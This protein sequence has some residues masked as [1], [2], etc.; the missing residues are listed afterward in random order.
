MKKAAQILSILFHPVLL[1]TLGFVLL[2]NSG[3]YFSFLSWEAQRYV[4][5]VVFF[6][7]A[8]LPLIGVA[9]LALRSNF[10]LSLKKNN[11][12]IMALFFTGIFYY[13]GFLLLGRIKAFPIF[14]VILLA[15]VLVIIAILLLSL[16]WKISAHMAALGSLTG[17]VFAIAFRTGINPFIPIL[18]LILASGL[19]GT[20]RLMLEK[21]NLPQIATGYIL[22]FLIVYL[23]IFFV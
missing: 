3:F 9:L 15:S 6:T 13:L 20:S 7:T 21:N 23:T 22:G 14:K 16:K 2:F 19:T 5:L 11:D 10:D 1:P 8:V 4:L 12:R 18:V 17:V